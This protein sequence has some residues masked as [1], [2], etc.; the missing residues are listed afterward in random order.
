MLSLT[1]DAIKAERGSIFVMDHLG[2]ATHKILARWYLPPHKS[3]EVVSV[4]LGDPMYRDRSLPSP[5]VTRLALVAREALERHGVAD[6]A[7]HILLAAE[8][9]KK[10]GVAKRDSQMIGTIR[11]DLLVKRTPFSDRDVE[12]VRSFLELNGWLAASSASF[13]PTISRTIS[14]TCRRTR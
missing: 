1:V 8:R 7:A 10:A 3:E 14:S 9:E 5:L 12:R 11:S 2:Q 4:V 6:P 13:A